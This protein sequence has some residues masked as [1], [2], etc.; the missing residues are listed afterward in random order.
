MLQGLEPLCSGARLGELGVLTWRRKGSRETSEPLP[1]PEGVPGE[2]ERDLG[3][4]ME[5]Q[6]TGDGFP[7]RQGRDGWDIG[8]EFFPGRMVRHSM[9]REAVA[10]PG[11]LEVSKARLDKVWNNLGQWKVSL[12]MA[13]VD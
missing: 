10:A 12:P 5:G 4:G 11:S 1:G 9:P 7:L 2:L 13:R 8:R 6:D 3:Q